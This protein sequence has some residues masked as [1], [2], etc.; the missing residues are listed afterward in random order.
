MSDFDCRAFGSSLSTR[1]V[2]T[3]SRD[4]NVRFVR[5]EPTRFRTSRITWYV[6]LKQYIWSRTRK[7]EAGVRL[8]TSS[9]RA[10]SELGTSFIIIDNDCPLY[11]KNIASGPRV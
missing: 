3:R 5:S 4:L 2:T 11:L 10:R 7:P 6:G 9:E 8:E 1:S